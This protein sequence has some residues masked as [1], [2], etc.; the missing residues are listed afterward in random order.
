M[1]PDRITYACVLGLCVLGILEAKS[2]EHIKS[3][4][5]F[6]QNIIKCKGIPGLS[7]AIVKDGETIISKGYGYADLEAELPVTS[8]TKFCVA[9]LTK[10][11]TSTLLADLLHERG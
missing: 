1:R 5:K 7:L 3:V 2:W 11:F 6:I 4:D 10:A 9:S 8:G